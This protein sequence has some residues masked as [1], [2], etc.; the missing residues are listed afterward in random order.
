ML[1]S[2]VQKSAVDE[3]RS[4]DGRVMQAIGYDAVLQDEAVLSIAW[5][6]ELVQENQH[7]DHDDGKGDGGACIVRLGGSKGDHL[8]PLFKVGIGSPRG[9]A[10]ES[11]RL[12]DT[13][14]ATARA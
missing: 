14:D 12:L 11:P 13:C 3:H 2:D 10:R 5:Q 7:V 9:A 6:A 4:E 8:R 1:P